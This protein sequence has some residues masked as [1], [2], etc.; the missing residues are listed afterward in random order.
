ME[1]SASMRQL[2]VYGGA[3]D[4][5]TDDEYWTRES[6]ENVNYTFGVLIGPVFAMYNYVHIKNPWATG[7]SH[8]RLN[9]EMYL[10]DVITELG[11]VEGAIVIHAFNISGPGP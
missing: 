1:T 10:K 11:L 2:R 5:H 4:K 7:V 3:D 8:V 6:F 9:R